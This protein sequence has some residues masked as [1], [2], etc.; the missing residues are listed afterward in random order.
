MLDTRNESPQ[1][2][3]SGSPTKSLYK[4]V[5]NPTH[6]PIHPSIFH[7]FIHTILSSIHPSIHH[8]GLCGTKCV[9]LSSVE[10]INLWICCSVYVMRA[11]FMGYIYI[12][13]CAQVH[14][15]MPQ[16]RDFFFFFFFLFFLILDI[17]KISRIYTKLFSK[18]LCLK[19]TFFF[20]KNGSLVPIGEDPNKVIVTMSIKSKV[21]IFWQEESL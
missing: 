21:E 7:S 17:S 3:G 10:Y 8:D 13:V 6:P 2:L 15:L 19:I 12:Y 16:S 18:F 9:S 11:I 20:S 1:I 5:F 14:F 4:L